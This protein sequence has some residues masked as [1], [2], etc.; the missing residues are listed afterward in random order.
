LRKNEIAQL[1]LIG[2]NLLICTGGALISGIIA[3]AIFANTWLALP[4]AVLF[5]LVTLIIT[6]Q[7]KLADRKSLQLLLN[8]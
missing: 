2:V 8:W 7:I 4:F 3:K 1:S 5:Y 6:A